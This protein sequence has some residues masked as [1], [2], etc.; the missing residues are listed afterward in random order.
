MLRERARSAEIDPARVVVGIPA[1]A[2]AVAA[3]TDAASHSSEFSGWVMDH[4]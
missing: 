2:A 1:T 4:R 3:F